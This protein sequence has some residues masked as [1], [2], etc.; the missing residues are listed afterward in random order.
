MAVVAEKERYEV[1]VG[2]GVLQHRMNK[3]VNRLWSGGRY[4]IAR[5]RQNSSAGAEGDVTP[6]PDRGGHD[7]LVVRAL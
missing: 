2:G 4:D 6:P 3:V 1:V 5:P 7:V